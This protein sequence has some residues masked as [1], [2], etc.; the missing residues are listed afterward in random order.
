LLLLNPT[1]GFVGWDRLKAEVFL[2][3]HTRV[4]LSTPAAT[5]IYRTLGPPAVQE[6]SIRLSEGAAVEYIPDHVI[7]FPGSTYRQSLAIDLAE[8]SIALIFDAW[9]VGRVAR[10][11]RWLF[12][13]FVN[14]ISVTCRGIPIFHDCAILSPGTM[15]LAGFGGMENLNY[16]AL[17]GVFAEDFENW[18]GL[19]E[20]VQRELRE[21]TFIISGVNLLSRCGCIIRLLA[22]F[23]PELNDAFVRVWMIAR[24]TL[25]GV[26]SFDLRKP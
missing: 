11:E 2:G 7:P 21:L 12:K 24:R 1:G 18:D 10:G 16:V 13:E 22:R 23:A 26:P 14:R 19:A 17:F 25:V 4:C 15:E 9:A 3:A 20:I 6:T 8:G 5:K